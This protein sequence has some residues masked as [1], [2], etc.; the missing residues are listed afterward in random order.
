MSASFPSFPR[1][2]LR[3]SLGWVEVDGLFDPLVTSAY[4][5]RSELFVFSCAVPLELDSGE[6]CRDDESLR[7]LSDRFVGC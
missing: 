1:A 7:G 3:F 6:W 5:V 4:G 2:D